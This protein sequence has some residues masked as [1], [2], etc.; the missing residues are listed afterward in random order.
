MTDR[1]RDIHLLVQ[2]V[3]RTFYDA[4]HITLLDQ[5]ALA[6]ERA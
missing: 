5:L 6:T 1:L 4:K 2:H 3:A